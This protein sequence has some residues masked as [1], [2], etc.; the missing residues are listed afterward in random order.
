MKKRCLLPLFLSAVLALGTSAP[1]F[2]QTLSL[3]TDGSDGYSG[4]VLMTLNTKRDYGLSDDFDSFWE[5][6][7][8]PGAQ[9]V[10]GKIDALTTQSEGDDT[11][12]TDLPAA[13]SNL[14]GLAENSSLQTQDT[15][16]KTYVV[17]EERKFL[18]TSYYGASTNPQKP[19][20]KPFTA[21]CV[22]VS[23]HC[24]LWFDKTAVDKN[25]SHYTK[26]QIAALQDKLE[27]HAQIMEKTFGNSERIDVDND[28]KVAFVFYP[29]NDVTTA[30][31]FNNVDLYYLDV[32]FEPGHYGNK[33]DMISVNCYCND[34]DNQP[35][36]SDATLAVLCHEWQHLINF[37]QAMRTDGATEPNV[38]FRNDTW[39]NECFS[40]SSIGIN[41]LENDLIPLQVVGLNNYMTRY[42]N[43]LTVP[44]VFKDAFVLSGSSTYI[45]WFLFGRYLSAQTEGYMGSALTD[46]TMDY[47][48]DGI[49]RGGDAVYQS[50][51]NAKID[52]QVTDMDGKSYNNV[53]NCNYDSLEKALTN[54]GYLGDGPSAKAGNLSEML[55]N[56]VIATAYRQTSGAYALGGTGKIDLSTLQAAKLDTVAETPQKLPGGYTAAF[57]KIDGDSIKT[58]GGGADIQ[59][60]G[61][62]VNYDGVQADGYSPV[63]GAMLVNKGTQ[64][65]LSTTDT[66]TTIRY[67]TDG[68]DPTATTG[69][70]YDG[71]PITIN[72]NTIIKAIDTDQWGASSV[73]TFYYTIGRSASATT[74]NI[75][76]IKGQPITPQTLTISLTGDQFKNLAVGDDV[77]SLFPNL[78]PGLKATV[79]RLYNRTDAV[80][81]FFNPTVQAAESTEAYNTMDVT[82]SGTPTVTGEVDLTLSIP[83]Q[84]LASGIAFTDVPLGTAK[85]DVTETAASTNAATGIQ[86]DN[87][88]MFIAI[89][90]IIA[91]VAI[92]IVAV[93][94]R[95]SKKPD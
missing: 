81:Q 85:I 53:G 6:T 86:A 42:H 27:A 10:S 57:T 51:L 88:P 18:T 4:N 54:M 48:G 93:K 94:R 13:D 49:I 50:V 90:L 95:N 34:A 84:Y 26:D 20:I 71:T 36:S 40:Q 47:T 62:T 15:P 32:P 89:G 43:T 29:F 39:L 16:E 8:V 7:G 76:G 44:F 56:F 19:E 21:E 70:V 87:T 11:A 92:I 9:G 82:I 5:A 79:S 91:A 64:V 74:V 52:S 3:D 25:L 66:N 1:A 69:K 46:N 72:S 38:K 17:G 60:V 59:H 31:T 75:D 61:I 24:T 37:S 12:L 63:S 68:S 55:R 2:A 41:G 65:S 30:G 80:A 77:T 83:A 67:T 23:D 28:G 33:M 58:E 78:T 45:Y 73:N 14:T 22:A 35:L